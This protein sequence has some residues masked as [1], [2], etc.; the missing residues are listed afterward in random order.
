M[1]MSIMTRSLLPIGAAAGALLA[2]AGPAGAQALPEATAAESLA[3]TLLTTTVT[4]RFEAD[5]NF[6]LDD[7][8]PG[9]SY[10]ADTRL[11]V[12]LLRQ[13]PTQAFT[14][15]FN[16]GLRALWEAEE[17]FEFTAASPSTASVG[18]LTEWAGGS[19]EAGFRV[20]QAR[21]DFDRPLD[22]ILGVDPITGA[23]LPPG[24]GEPPLG[25]DGGLL[26]GDDGEL[27]DDLDDLEG[28]T[29]ER[30][31][32]ADVLLALV[33]GGPSSYEFSL[34][35]TRF[36]YSD[37]STDRVPR[38]TLR[39][40]AAWALRLTPVLSSAVVARYY[41]YDADNL[42]ETRIRE[43]ELDAGVIYD[44]S[45]ALRLS[46]GLGYV[47]RSREATR[48]GET[49]TVEDGTGPAIRAGVRYR[50]EALTI[51]AQ[52][53]IFDAAPDT[54]FSGNLRVIYPLRIAELNAR[55]FRDQVSSSSGED[56]RLTGASIGFERELSRVSRLGLDFSAA[57]Q[58]NEDD[59]DEPDVR[60]LDATA[61]YSRDLTDV[62]TA[63]LGYSFRTREEG[64][65]DASSHAVF[66]QIGR[67][68]E[69]RF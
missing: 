67:S 29:V 17:D 2:L 69:T 3:G 18:Y 56:V 14:L 15:G 24:E 21:V 8:S 46:A 33:P 54:R 45:E 25:E 64:P 51:D 42:A 43:A 47:D 1:P 22:D 26:P 57:N 68:F 58:V 30:R 36:E 49:V 4:Q 39:G 38:T 12:G 10:F 55:A 34:D 59:P 52:G 65:E 28:E 41:R 19:L 60:R 23:P 13:T 37:E 53:R 48:R 63:D 61:V 7:P 44:A 32:D 31:Y 11:A 27:P 62:I 9:T 40:S 20:R 50:L 5:T 6:S 66:F 35:A 16:T